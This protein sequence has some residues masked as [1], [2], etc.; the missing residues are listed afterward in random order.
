MTSSGT[1]YFVSSVNQYDSY[2][3]PVYTSTLI[4]FSKYVSLTIALYNQYTGT[5]M[6][7]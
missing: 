5:Y 4:D 6:S 3:S 2:W 1:I 7:P